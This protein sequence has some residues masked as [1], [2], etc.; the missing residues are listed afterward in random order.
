MG[1]WRGNKRIGA[2]LAAFAMALQVWLSLGHVHEAAW[3][4]Q[5]AEAG[6]ILPDYAKA[7]NHSQSV[8]DDDDCP[9]CFAMHM[10]AGGALPVAPVL[11]TPADLRPA[12]YRTLREFE[13]VA[14]RHAKYR[15][16]APPRA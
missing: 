5:G 7:P 1:F 16:R 15:T 9:I 13:L 8:P 14:R 12:P 2:T 3:Q 6:T 10:A 4:R 11:A